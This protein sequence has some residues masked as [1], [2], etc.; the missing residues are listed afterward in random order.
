M[1]AAAR[2]VA[3]WRAGLLPLMAAWRQRLASLPLTAAVRLA[4]LPPVRC[5]QAL[6]RRAEQWLALSS[7]VRS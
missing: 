6:L 2:R 1:A 3:W 4:F 5:R 7:L